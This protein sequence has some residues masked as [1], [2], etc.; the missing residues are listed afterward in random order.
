MKSSLLLLAVLLLSGAARAQ[1]IYRTYQNARFGTIVRYPQNLVVPQP[2]SDDGDGRKFVSPDGQIELTTYARHNRS[3]R[4]A[5]GELNRA[6]SD[7]KR[8]GARLTYARSGISWF[9]LSGFL[10]EDIFYE[11]T[12]LQNGV[13]H[14]LIWQYPKVSKKRLDASVSR[15]AAAFSASRGRT[16]AASIP[17]SVPQRAVQP[18]VKKRRILKTRP[19]SSAQTSGY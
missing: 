7:W 2:E 5:R 1:D 19:S 10:G 15:S 18:R 13:F 12:L 9:V 8:D 6:V 11:K 16:V 14:T 3:R 4:S 17:T